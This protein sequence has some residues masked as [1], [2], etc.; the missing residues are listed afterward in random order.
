ME[1]KLITPQ[2][3]KV[4]ASGN[5]TL[6]GYASTWEKDRIGDIVLPG[7]FKDTIAS[8]L[9]DGFIA[10]SHDWNRLPIATPI[11]AREDATGLL[12]TAEFHSTSE[13]QDARR[14]IQ[15]RID[16][17]KSVKMSIGY[18]VLQDEYTNRGRL[19]KKL[20]LYEVSIVTVPAN[21][22]AQVL[23][24]KHNRRPL[25]RATQ[26]SLAEIKRRLDSGLYDSGVSGER[27][28][29]REAARKNGVKI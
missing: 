1:H 24:A 22:G 6:T 18:Q 8:W 29:L 2:R 23:A 28:R 25:D 21:M 4:S 20:D 13:A 27:A 7:A 17:G 15:E 26:S 10:L 16:R 12:I 19:L 14:V 11:E 3:L 9:R 5:G